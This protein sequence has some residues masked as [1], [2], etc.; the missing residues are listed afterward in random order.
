MDTDGHSGFRHAPVTKWLVPVIG[1][2]SALTTFFNSR[3]SLEITQLPVHDQ[4][5]RIFTSHWAFNSIGTTVIG[6]WLTY[7]LRIVERR[8]GSAKYAAF[9]FITF[10]ASTLVQ[11]SALWI[12]SRFGFRSIAEGPYAI[13]FAILCQFHQIIPV[14]YQTPVLG[15]E[16]TDKSYAYLAAVQLLLS[17]SGTA[18]VPA[19]S[20]IAI[21]IIY[22]QSKAIQ[23]W[24]FPSWIRSIA[25]KYLVGTYHKKNASRQPSPRLQQTVAVDQEDI[26]TMLA[27][28]PNYSR[29]E[30]ER[31]LINSRSDL[32]R[33]AEVL[34]S[35][36]PS[37]GS[38]S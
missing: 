11:T 38:S 15:M 7:R 1:V 29:Q 16:F 35:S 8:Y 19:V 9:V 18:I 33:A 6:T 32:N 21:G 27:M 34:L 17:N 28:F 36:E 22:R 24:R 5:W 37:A 30:V 10:M 3:P 14:T 4:L 25:S 31:A 13:L 23:Q 12:G 2:S 20:G 26:E